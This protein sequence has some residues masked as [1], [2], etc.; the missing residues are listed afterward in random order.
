[1]KIEVLESLILFYEEILNK[2]NIAHMPYD[3]NSLNN[4]IEGWTKTKSKLYNKHY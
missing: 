2:E 3:S 4:M 1:M